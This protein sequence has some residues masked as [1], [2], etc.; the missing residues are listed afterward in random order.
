MCWATVYTFKL[1][2]QVFKYPTQQA[3]SVLLSFK[4]PF[5]HTHSVLIFS[6]SLYSVG[7]SFYTQLLLNKMSV[8]KKTA[9]LECNSHTIQ[10]THFNIQLTH[11]FLAY[12]QYC[13]AIL[14]I[15]FRAFPSPHNQTHTHQQSFSIS[16]QCIS[17][18][19]HTNVLCLYR[20]A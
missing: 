10:F 8:L 9:L 17:L 15:N 20:F 5:T 3:F 19:I 2:K 13:A 1:K 11:W 18:S 7:Q 16:H 12:S 4:H 14:T 6:L